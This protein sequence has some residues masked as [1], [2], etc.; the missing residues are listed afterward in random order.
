MYFKV[1]TALWPADAITCQSRGSLVET[2]EREGGGEA[3]ERDC[4]GERE[5]RGMERTR[6]RERER[7]KRLKRRASERERLGRELFF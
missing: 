6:D 3:R 4:T 7:E 5:G 1:F 2:R